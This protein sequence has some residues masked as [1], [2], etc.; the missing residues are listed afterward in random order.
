M[1][2]HRRSGRC[3]WVIL[4]FLLYV[5]QVSAEDFPRSGSVHNTK[6]V[7]SLS[8]KCSKRDSA[9]IEC[10]F[11]Q[12]GVRLQAKSADLQDKLTDA[13]GEYRSGMKP[14]SKDEC[15]LYQP[16]L[17]TLEGRL[18]PPRPEG[19]AEL[20]PV[21]RTD[22]LAMAKAG[23]SYCQKP[24]EDNYLKLIQGGCRS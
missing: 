8:F 5:I 4:L 12:T 18:N 13:R 6:E 15:N 17:D 23:A 1:D 22:A 9:T 19:Y 7:R 24:T 14:P 2:E 20:S 21:A 3:V 10:D 16:L 11:L